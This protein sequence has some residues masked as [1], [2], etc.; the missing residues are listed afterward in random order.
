M[1]RRTVLLLPDLTRERVLLLLE[2]LLAVL[3]RHPLRRLDPLLQ[4]GF[5]SA[6]QVVH[7]LRAVDAVL[8]E[9]FLQ[10]E[11]DDVLRV[12]VRP[13]LGRVVVPEVLHQ[14]R[15]SA[16]PPP[17]PHLQTLRL[18]HPQ[19][20]LLHVIYVLEQLNVPFELF[21]VKHWSLLLLLFSYISGI[22]HAL[23]VLGLLV[24]L[25]AQTGLDYR[26]LRQ[27]VVVLDL[28]VGDHT[29]RVLFEHLIQ[30]LVARLVVHPQVF[31]PVQ[32]VLASHVLVKVFLCRILLIRLREVTGSRVSV[33]LMR[34]RTVSGTGQVGGKGAGAVGDR[35][36]SGLVL[37]G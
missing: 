28:Y 23:I 8:F 1:P 34:R 26:E 4:Y 11:L 2:H 33:L 14:S 19:F 35:V 9:Q 18:F 37:A 25:V 30:L 15:E 10:L 36:L 24:V 16:A 6:G 22:E 29:D 27:T 32:F 13:L 3:D 17:L 5:E 21:R 7:H 20:L 31:L 12:L